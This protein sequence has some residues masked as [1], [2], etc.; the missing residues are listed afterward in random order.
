MVE[1]QIEPRT[2]WIQGYYAKH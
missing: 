1:V 2:F